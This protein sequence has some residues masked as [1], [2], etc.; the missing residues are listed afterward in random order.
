MVFS[1]GKDH[2]SRFAGTFC[3]QFIWRDDI[4]QLFSFLDALKSRYLSPFSKAVGL[5]ADL[6]DP[7]LIKAE[8]ISRTIQY[9]RSEPKFDF[10]INRVVLLY[11]YTYPRIVAND[12]LGYPLEFPA[13][14]GGISLP[15]EDEERV[16]RE[17][18]KYYA[19]CKRLLRLNVGELFLEL[20]FSSFLSLGSKKGFEVKYPAFLT[21]SLSTKINQS[22]LFET[23]SLLELVQAL[24]GH[25]PKRTL[26]TGESAPHWQRVRK[27]LTDHGWYDLFGLIDTFKRIY[28]FETGFVSPIEDPKPIKV[29]IEHYKKNFDTF[30]RDRVELALY[31]ADDFEITI[32]PTE[33]LKKVLY[34]LSGAYLSPEDPLVSFILKGPSLIMTP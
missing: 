19:Y 2:E 12:T 13:G 6:R 30:L 27:I 11:R 3:E 14:L 24:V 9:L 34:R 4:H 7:A 23:D 8:V 31:D 25:V 17:H 32:M 16:C 33:I 20:F 15:T 10:L 18:I 22:R 26:H 5:E 21:S 28:E 1:K 29:R